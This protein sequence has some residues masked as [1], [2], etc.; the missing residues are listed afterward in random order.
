MTHVFYYQH[1]DRTTKLVVVDGGYPGR[2]SWL[3]GNC[4]TSVML[5]PGSEDEYHHDQ[6]QSDDQ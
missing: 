4:N 5:V 1:T 6:L 2:K 3:W